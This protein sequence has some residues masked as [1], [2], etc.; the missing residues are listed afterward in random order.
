MW[1]EAKKNCSNCRFEDV[2]YSNSTV[3][4]TSFE[5]LVN[6]HPYGKFDRWYETDGRLHWALWCEYYESGKPI[7][8]AVEGDLK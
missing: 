1:G 5:C 3:E 6:K 4:G 8:I 7:H 2:G